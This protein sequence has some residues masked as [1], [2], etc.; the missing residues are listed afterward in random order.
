MD[1]VIEKGLDLLPIEA[2]STSKK[3]PIPKGLRS[4]IEK[5]HPE[6]ALVANLSA[7]RNIITLN[8]TKVEFVLPFQ[9]L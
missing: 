5:F 9:M 1:F 7:E 3:A 4:F 6:K 8:K 2:K